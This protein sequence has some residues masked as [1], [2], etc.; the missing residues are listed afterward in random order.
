MGMY[1]SPPTGWEREEMSHSPAHTGSLPSGWKTQ[2]ED[3]QPQGASDIL[4]APHTCTALC[5]EAILC[6]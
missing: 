1:A 5:Q 6:P 2:I 3:F 4:P